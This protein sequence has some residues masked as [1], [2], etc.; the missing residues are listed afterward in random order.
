[1]NPVYD[2]SEYAT[3]AIHPAMITLGIRD[4]EGLPTLLGFARFIAGSAGL[5]ELQA[6]LEARARELVGE[7]PRA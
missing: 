4:A 3:K 7:E 5:V 6:L 1:L 2:A